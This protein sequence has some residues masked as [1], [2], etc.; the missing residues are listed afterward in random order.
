[1]VSVQTNLSVLSDFRPGFKPDFKSGIK[2]SSFKTTGQTMI[3]KNILNDSVKNEIFQFGSQIRTDT[4]QNLSDQNAIFHFNQL[5]KEDKASLFYK[6]TPISELSSKEANDLISNDGYFGIE[7]TSQRITEF[8]IKGAGNDIDRLKAGREGILRGFGEAEKAWGGKLPDISY[9]TI[10]KSLETIDEKIRE[11][12][13]S[14]VD[15]ST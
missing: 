14:V 13:G 3:K 8:V 2:H 15:L 6:N 7:K 4:R 10:A 5:N 11:L 1:M 9:E 12:G